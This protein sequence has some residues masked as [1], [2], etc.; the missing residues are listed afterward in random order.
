MLSDIIGLLELLCR[1]ELILYNISDVIC[2]FRGA[3]LFQKQWFLFSEGNDRCSL[4]L[5]DG[6]AIDI[7]QKIDV[8]HV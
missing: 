1:V 4:S 2:T 7:Y 6:V 3:N 8:V 5:R